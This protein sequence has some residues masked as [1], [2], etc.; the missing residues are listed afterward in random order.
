[1]HTLNLYQ[2]FILEGVHFI[3]SD[4]PIDGVHVLLIRNDLCHSIRME[5]GGSGDTNTN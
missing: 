4:L 3:I 5:G 2:C 1:M